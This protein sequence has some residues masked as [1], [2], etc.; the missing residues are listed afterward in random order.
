MDS[1]FTY[2]YRLVA[3]GYNMAPTLFIAY[4]SVVTSKSVILAFLIAGLNYL[5]IYA[6]TIVNAY[7]NAPCWGKLWTKTGS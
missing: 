5:D 3:G 4:S 6:C 1:K 7:I 2:K